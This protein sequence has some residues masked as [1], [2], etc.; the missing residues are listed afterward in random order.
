MI[1]SRARGILLAIL[2]AAPAWAR[3]APA[4]AQSIRLQVPWVHD[5]VAGVAL[6]LEGRLPLGPE[7]ELP[8]PGRPGAGPVEVGTRNWMLTGMIGGGVNAAPPGSADLT[9]LL[10]VHGGI[11]RRT[12]SELVSRAGIVV[13]AYLPADAVG[14]AARVGAFAGAVELQAGALHT[15]PGWRAH[16]ALDLSARFLRDLLIR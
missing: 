3:P 6:G 13:V 15:E 9:G 4:A 11:L 8:L 16:V 1:R 14:P 12:G 5:A 10:V 7:P 2:A